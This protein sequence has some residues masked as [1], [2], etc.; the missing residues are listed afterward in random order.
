M[1]LLVSITDVKKQ[2]FDEIEDLKKDELENLL[3]HIRLNKW[4][5][6]KFT[7]LK[8]GAKHITSKELEKVRH[9]SK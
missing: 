5:N 1:A 8:K 7:S 2:I 4:R 9:E 6:I 3:R